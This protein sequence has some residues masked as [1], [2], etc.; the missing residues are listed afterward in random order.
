[1]LG[2]GAGPCTAVQVAVS[3]SPGS[4]PVAVFPVGH[5]GLWLDP[6]DLSTMFQD[7]AGTVPVTS[8]GDPVRLLM[9]K[10]GNGNHV[11]A[12]SDAERPVYQDADGLHWLEFDGVDDELATSTPLPF[13]TEVFN[14]TAF[15]SLSYSSSY[16]NIICNRGPAGGSENRQP[17][18]FLRSLNADTVSASFG[19]TGK[20]V[21]LGTAVT[22]LDIVAHALASASKNELNANGVVAAGGGV[23]LTDGSTAPFTVGGPSQR[24]NMRFYGTMQVNGL[25][26]DAEIAAVRAYFAGKSGGVA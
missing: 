9:D 19:G 8:P 18:L 12:S 11:V 6:S 21:S 25:P 22:G 26:T 15:R 13:A 23:M 5:S 20:L 17:L 16:P 1:M 2:I 24:A 14:C 3:A 7:A 4:D 10:S